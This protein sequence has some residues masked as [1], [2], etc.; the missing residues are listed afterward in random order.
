MYIFIPSEFYSD[1][2]N[3]IVSLSKHWSRY[4]NVVTLHEE[5]IYSYEYV[6]SPGVDKGILIARR[7]L[8][9]DQIQVLHHGIG[10]DNCEEYFFTAEEAVAFVCEIILSYDEKN[11]VKLSKDAKV[12]FDGYVNREPNHYWE[13]KD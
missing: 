11:L 5:E 10:F 6:W 7:E 12:I 1:D 13:L 8:D 9:T 2:F 4:T 3:N